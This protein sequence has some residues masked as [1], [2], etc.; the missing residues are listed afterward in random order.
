M[1]APLAGSYG[2]IHGRR[3]VLFA[4]AAGLI[5]LAFP[6]YLLV[7]SDGLLTALVGQILLAC[8]LAAVA[9]VVVIAQAELFSTHV[10]YT[11]AALGYNI[12]YSAFGGT[13]PFVGQYLVGA[14]NPLAPALYLMVIAGLSLLAIAPMPET[15]RA[16]MS[17]RDNR[18]LSQPG[19]LSG[20]PAGSR[21]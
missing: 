13:A 6:A 2:D 21:P 8:P 4:G 10:R 15:Y 9:S 17:R 16:S 19:S 5:V 7:G 1:I 20:E 12:A 3:R 11:G 18:P 14:I